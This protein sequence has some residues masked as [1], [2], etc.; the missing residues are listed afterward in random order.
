MEYELIEQILAVLGG[1]ARVFP[2]LGDDVGGLLLPENRVLLLKTDFVAEATDRPRGMT[3]WEL[4]WKAVSITVSDFAAKGVQPQVLVAS[5]GGPRRAMRRHVLDIVRG[6]QEACEYYDVVY[7]GGD[8]GGCRE[9]FIATAAAAL[10]EQ[11]RIVLRS[12]ARP[13]DVVLTTGSFGL[14]GI[15]LALLERGV[16]IGDDNRLVFRNL[17][18]PE[19]RLKAGVAL[20]EQGIPTAAIDS[21]DGLAWSLYEIARASHTA[22]LVEELPTNDEVRELASQYN[23]DLE[24]ACLYGGEELE[25]VFTTPQDKVQEAVRLLEDL[26]LQPYVIGRVLSEEPK[27]YLQTETGPTIIQPYGY[28]HFLL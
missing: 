23:V 25:L 22:I 9:I 4:G 14:N 7:V 24:Q 19:A 2:P 12:G 17:L 21:S 10:T 1:D 6:I 16:E 26:K 5:I 15:A 28:Q 3:L 13:G 8:L 20:A 27:I 11:N 18:R